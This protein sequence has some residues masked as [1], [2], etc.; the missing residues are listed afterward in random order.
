MIRLPNLF[1]SL[2][3]FVQWIKVGQYD[4]CSLP[5]R[6]KMHLLPE[7]EIALW[8]ISGSYDGKQNRLS[9]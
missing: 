8:K 6:L 5:H 7:D 1:T 9:V 2:Q 4:Y 3:I